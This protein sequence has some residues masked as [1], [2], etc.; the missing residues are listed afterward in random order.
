MFFKIIN[1]FKRS[2]NK[3][4]DC[5][6]VVTQFNLLLDGALNPKE[7]QNV[8]CELQRCIH[9]LEEYNLEDKYRVYLKERVAKKYCPGELLAKLKKCIKGEE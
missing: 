2:M 5:K 3:R 4:H 7:E 9:C 8:M 6:E 1:N